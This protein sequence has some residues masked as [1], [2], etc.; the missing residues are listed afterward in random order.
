MV[1]RSGMPGEH[2]KFAARRSGSAGG[3]RA[4]SGSE[5]R[6]RRAERRGFARRRRAALVIAIADVVHGGPWGYVRGSPWPCR[7]EPW[8]TRSSRAEGRWVPGP[9]DGRPDRTRGS[10][11]SPGGRRWR[12][13][14][15]GRA[16]P[17]GAYASGAPSASTARP[18]TQR[19]APC[20]SV[21]R[22]PP[23]VI[24]VMVPPLLII[25][26]WRE[27]DC[28]GKR[29][30]VT[31]YTV[32]HDASKYVAGDLSHP[33]SAPLPRRGPPPGEGGCPAGRVGTRTRPPFQSGLAIRRIRSRDLLRRRGDGRRP[34]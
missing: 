1:G 17:G 21:I 8:W 22:P 32:P 19:I 6:A 29:R 10:T 14:P 11:R 33:R 15:A 3:R 2:I 4:C 28:G 30:A 27:D 12:G 25:L 7:G 13:H 16:P 5:R 34:G 18:A 26:S 9:S 20:S 31:W 23:T 24:V